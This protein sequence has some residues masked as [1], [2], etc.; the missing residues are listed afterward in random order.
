MTLA[1]ALM[2]AMYLRT[3]RRFVGPHL[4][5]RVVNAHNSNRPSSPGEGRSVSLSPL[6]PTF[7]KE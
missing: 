3:L 4:C 6:R 5:W 1:Q 7:S 2:R